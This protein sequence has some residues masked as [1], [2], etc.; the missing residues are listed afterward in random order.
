[1]KKSFL[2]LIAFLSMAISAQAGDVIQLGVV[3]GYNL[4]AVNFKRGSLD[5][6]LV[7]KNGSGW[8]LGPKVQFNA[9]RG[10][11]LNAALVYNQ[12]RYTLENTVGEQSSK[13]THSFNIP[14]NLKYSFEVRG[15]GVHFTTGPN[16]AFNV[17]NRSWNF[18]N[19]LSS[20]KLG[21]TS[22]EVNGVFKNKVINTTWNIGAGI[23]VFSALDLG[24]VYNFAIGK[25]GTSA[26]N[27]TGVNAGNLVLPSYK[28]NTFSLQ[29]SY[30][31]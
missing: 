10:F 6:T 14:L 29:A 24:I 28:T 17:G 21:N 13:T 1:M 15:T 2:S 25:V 19:L 22:Y 26:L 23:N 9:F 4:T 3:G 18:S 12:C 20:K 11:G 7:G 5:N 8:Y 27:Q 30:Y 16:F 31:F